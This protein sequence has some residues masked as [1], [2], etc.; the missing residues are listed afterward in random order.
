MIN[1]LKKNMQFPEEANVREKYKDVFQRL[2]D[3]E[4]EAAAMRQTFTKGGVITKEQLASY[5]I[6]TPDNPIG[7]PT[8]L[9][10]LTY[11]L[12]D[13]NGNMMFYTVCVAPAG[14]FGCFGKHRHLRLRETNIQLTGEGE[15]LG[16]AV[17]TFGILVF[18]PGTPHDY[19]MCSSSSL[20]TMFEE[21]IPR[22]K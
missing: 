21:V 17:G 20:L 19:I 12:P 22:A 8:G 5:A 9:N 14:E 10:C 16:N 2:E 3:L 13:Y 18:E 11:R 4:G 6:S 1:W 7:Y 15:C